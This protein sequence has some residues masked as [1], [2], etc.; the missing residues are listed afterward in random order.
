MP[1]FLSPPFPF[2]RDELRNED[3]S[4]RLNS[5]RRLSTIALALGEERTRREL[6]PFLEESHD[7]EDEVLLVVSE[8]LGKFV[9]LVGGPPFAHTLLPPLEALASVDETVVRDSAAASLCTV[10]AALPPPDIEKYFVP[11]IQRLQAK[12]WT[13]RVSA[14][15]L[16]ATAYPHATPHTRSDLRQAFAALARDETPMVRRATAAAFGKLVKV[17]EPELVLGEELAVFERLT[18]DEQDSVRLISVEACGPLAT[19][20]KQKNVVSQHVLPVLLRFAGDKSWRVR[21]NAAT[22]VPELAE[23]LGTDISRDSLLPEFTKLL[24]DSE[25][26]VRAAAAGRIASFCAVLSPKDITTDIV[27]CCRELAGDPSQY[28]RT[29]LAGVITELAPKLGKK[30]TTEQLLPVYLELLRDEC[31]EVRLGIIGNLD[32]VGKVVGVDQLN[33]QLLPAIEGLAGDKHWRVRLAIIGHVPLLAE[34][35]GPE[36]LQQKLG[37]QCIK[38]LQ[39]QVFSIREA[40]TKAL[41]KLA[42]TFGSDWSRDV[43]IPDVLKTLNDSNYLYRETALNAI[44][45][46]AP[47]VNRKVLDSTLL[48]AVMQ[49]ATKDAVPNVRFNAAKVLEKIAPLVDSAVVEKIIKPCLSGMTG[50][51]DADVQF[52][53][54]R[55]LVRCDAP[56]VEMK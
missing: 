2:H 54:A 48:P 37:P 24:R 1:Q 13:S 29:A 36:F 5:V 17:V 38:W 43:L 39:D 52:F 56:V 3:V 8:E 47:H 15:Q 42:A 11:M 23:V 28:V 51:G 12:E 31:P 35:L 22:Q 7:D 14:C 21:Y 6:L 27:P 34:Q 19:S 45:C 53:A 46:L 44:A 49:V 33:D 16:F 20:L 32:A 10:G 4:L 40:A 25:A 50:D 30:T 41:E 26:E 18:E 55:A 9:P